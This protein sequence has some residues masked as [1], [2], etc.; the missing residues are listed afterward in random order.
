MLHYICRF[1]WFLMEDPI[2]QVEQTLDCL[3]CYFHLR[4]FHKTSVKCY[5]TRHT[6]DSVTLPSV[7]ELKS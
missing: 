3:C 2:S 1:A 5:L 6:S 7:I 4:V